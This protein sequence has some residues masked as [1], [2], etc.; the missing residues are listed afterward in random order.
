MEIYRKG[1]DTLNGE[2]GKRRD[3]TSVAHCESLFTLTKTSIH[4]KN[5]G[6]LMCCFLE[7]QS[8][9]RQRERDRI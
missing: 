5:Q 7:K 6:N 8:H 9:D 2:M 4:A 1:W 3:G